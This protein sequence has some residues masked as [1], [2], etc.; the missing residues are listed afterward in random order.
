MS[1]PK[2]EYAPLE[3]NFDRILTPIERFMHDEAA[4]G[5]V[6]MACAVFALVIANSPLMAGYQ[7]ILHTELGITI[8]AWS[9]HHSV[10]H[11]INEGL[12]TLFFFVVGL[13]IKRE[14][15]VGELSTPRQAAVPVFAAIGGMV[16]PALI[17]LAFNY[18]GP[19]AQGWGVPM[20]TDIAFAVGVL[21][22]LGSRIPRTVATFLVALAIVDDLGAVLV[23]AL[24]YTESL[25]MFALAASGGFLALLVLLNVLGIRKP[26]PYFLIGLLL[27]GGMM[28]SGI[29]ATL[30]G[31]LTALT[32]PSRSKFSFG[33]FAEIITRLAERITRRRQQGCD[34]VSDAAERRGA[35]QS[36]EKAVHMLETPL[37]ALEHR[38]HLPVAFFIVPLFA[39]ANAGIAIDF[40]TLSEVLRQPIS[41]GIMAGL[42]AGKMIGV[43]GFSLLAIV[44][45]LGELPKGFLYRH[46]IGVGL[47]AGI[48]FTMSI[49]IA[50]LGFS[51]HD[52]QLLLAKTGI[53]FASLVAGITGYLWLAMTS[54]RPKQ[55]GVDS[56][57]DRD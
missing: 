50:E 36:M 38:W 16:A 25:N 46:L 3:R 39:L 30:A 1:E 27:W 43:V 8:G 10:H 53:L 28:E 31:V 29:H 5:L 14:V 23:I 55:A 6:L 7:L 20:A 44:L 13:E 35:L 34:L 2:P 22:L 26:L 32:I 48:G 42:L 57:L 54:P 18:G 56:A 33:V 49:F 40:G 24:F 47:L 41:L 4:G 11:W 15:L 9:L 52:D 37:Q 17:Y 19:G 21:A 12:M 51:G 45:G